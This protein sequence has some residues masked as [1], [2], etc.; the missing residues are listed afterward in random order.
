MPLQECPRCGGM[1]E[2]VI[3]ENHNGIHSAVASP[4]TEEPSET[5]YP[6]VDCPEWCKVM[7]PH[8]HSQDDMSVVFDD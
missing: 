1:F 5:G 7:Y 3:S 8:T 4:A 6:N 2:V